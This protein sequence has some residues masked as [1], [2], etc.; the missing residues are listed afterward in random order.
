[1]VD[2]EEWAMGLDVGTCAYVVLGHAEYVQWCV[3]VVKILRNGATG[4]DLDWQGMD[5]WQLGGVHACMHVSMI[6][7][8]NL[9]VCSFSGQILWNGRTG[10]DPDRWVPK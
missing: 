4:M 5:Q 10:M 7:G 3:S 9:F 8:M 6:V 1:M 2:S